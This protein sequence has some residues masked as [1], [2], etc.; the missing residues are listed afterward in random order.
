MADETVYERLK[1]ENRGLKDPGNMLIAVYILFVLFL[2][3]FANMASANADGGRGPEGVFSLECSS[4]LFSPCLS[5]DVPS[6]G[7]SEK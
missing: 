4:G 5:A 7:F 6:E 2:L 3:L 1:Q